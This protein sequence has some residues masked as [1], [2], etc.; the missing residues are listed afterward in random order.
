[1]VTGIDRRQMFTGLC[2]VG[3]LACLG[4]S[5]LL[6]AADAAPHK[7]AASAEMSF[8]ELYEFAYVRSFI[9]TMKKLAEAVGLDTIREAASEAAAESMKRTAGMMPAGDATMFVAMFNTPDR[10]WS[11]VLTVDVVESTPAASEVRVT[12]CLWAKAFRGADAADIGYAC[13]CHPDYAMATA[14]N[15][16][17]H[18]VRDKT[19]MQGHSHCNHRWVHEA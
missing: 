3:S 19:L 12:E 18:L 14:V 1:M 13:I 10:F 6:S 7:F 9:P 8:E 4:G 2:A 11:H 15:P 5:R 17:V 16:K